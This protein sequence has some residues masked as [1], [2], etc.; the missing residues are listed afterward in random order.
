MRHSSLV[1][2]SASCVALLALLAGCGGG[3]GSA[4]ATSAWP[5]Y[6]PPAT[7]VPAAARQE[8]FA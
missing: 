5:S 4:P 3:G 6:D 1:L 8:S 7:I 2:L